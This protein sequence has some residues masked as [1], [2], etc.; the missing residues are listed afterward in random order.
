M[1]P[2]FIEDGE[3]ADL[4][5]ALVRLNLRQSTLTPQIRLAYSRI[6]RMSSALGAMELIRFICVGLSTLYLAFGLRDG[7]AS[8]RGNWEIP[9]LSLLLVLGTTIVV[10]LA[11]SPGS[12]LSVTLACTR[13]V[14]LCANAHQTDFWLRADA[15]HKVGRACRGVERAVRRQAHRS[16][17]VPLLSHRRK[18]LRR[19]AALVITAIRQQEAQLDEADPHQALADLAQL[20]MTVADNAAAEHIGA[21]LPPTHTNGLEPTRS[22]DWL[23]LLIATIVFVLVAVTASKLD[24]P[25]PVVNV[26]VGTSLLVIVG[27]L[28]DYR[29][30]HRL[31][32][33][34]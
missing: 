32:N 18:R 33:L 25:D 27:M 9:V 26:I 29:Q 19:H 21:L 22:W 10:R 34:M 15:F 6:A 16:G 11:A 4:A 30:G 7:I 20:L 28:F 14:A 23:R 8:L 17:S 5:D 12:R 31:F 3:T 13:T 2:S 1:T 24:L